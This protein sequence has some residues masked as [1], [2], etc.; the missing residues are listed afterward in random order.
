VK[1]K[2]EKLFKEHDQRADWSCSASAHEFVAKLH[3]KV[4]A[5]EYPLQSDA[6]AAHK[7]GFEFESFLNEHGFTGHDEHSPPADAVKQFENETAEKRFP[8]VSLVGKNA[9]GKSVAHIAVAVPGENGVALAD[10]GKKTL[11]TRNSDE[12]RELLENV[13]GAI[14][15][16][17]NIHCLF[18]KEK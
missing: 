13:S 4:P 12:T 16:R 17:P 8:L 14:P 10:P 3:G 1:E 6:E 2:V 9:E 11:I 18:Y 5:C 7:A 15:D